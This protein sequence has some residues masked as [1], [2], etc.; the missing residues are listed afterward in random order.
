[1]EIFT[2]DEDIYRYPA[3]YYYKGCKISADIERSR[4]VVVIR[5]SN[6]GGEHN[7]GFKNRQNYKYPKLSSDTSNFQQFCWQS[8][9][10]LNQ[11]HLPDNRIMESGGTILRPDVTKWIASS[12]PCHI[13]KETSVASWSGETAVLET[14]AFWI[15][16]PYDEDAIIYPFGQSSHDNRI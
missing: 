16:G 12:D 3:N 8:K 10:F 1:M 5:T 9:C 7:Y 2:A 6:Q 13:D 4:S 15:P 11:E 14:W